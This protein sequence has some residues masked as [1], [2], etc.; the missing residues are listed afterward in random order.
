MAAG[1]LDL[2]LE[3]DDRLNPSRGI[4]LDTRK[5]SFAAQDDVLE[6]RSNILEMLPLAQEDV[7]EM[8]SFAEEAI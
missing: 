3:D 4:I 6:M 2:E 1:R 8:R 7:L 5:L